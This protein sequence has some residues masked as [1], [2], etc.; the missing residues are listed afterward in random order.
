MAEVLKIS[1]MML[2]IKSE[3][4]EVLGKEKV[5]EAAYICRLPYLR[6]ILRETLRLH[7]P[8]PFLVPCQIAE[9]TEVNGYIIPK[10]Y[11]VLVNA[12]AIGRDPV[13]WENP[14]SF[15]SE[16]FLDSEVL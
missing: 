13:S 9:E 12:W 2:K 10:N 14:Q 1:E 15:Q 6:C 4:R 8:L 7:P 16:R 5:I 11:Q 3:L